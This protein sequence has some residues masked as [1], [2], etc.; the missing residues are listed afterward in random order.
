M[1]QRILTALAV[2]AVTAVAAQAM[3]VVEHQGATNPT[4]QG[5]TACGEASC[6]ETL[7]SPLTPDAG[8]GVDAWSINDDNDFELTYGYVL[9]ASETAVAQSQGWRVDTTVRIPTLSKGL[10]SVGGHYQFRFAPDKRY[11]LRWSTDAAGVPT[12]YVLGDGQ[13]SFE[14]ASAGYHDY[15]LRYDPNTDTADLFI[16]GVERISGVAPN[17]DPGTIQLTWGSG[18]SSGH[19]PA[20]ANFNAL[21]LFIVPEP[22]SLALLGLGGLV[23]LGRRRR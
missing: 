13:P 20:Q 15:S 17:I 10:D 2:L 16:D 9:S 4:A 19:D 12:A 14:L 3:V 18:A 23:A 6:S 5:W 11:F 1:T 21:S 8:F 7:A 22:A